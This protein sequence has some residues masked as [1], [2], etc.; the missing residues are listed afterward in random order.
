[1][2]NLAHS[3]SFESLDK[4]APS[5]AGTKQLVPNAAGRWAPAPA[6]PGSQTEPGLIVYRFG[7]DL[8]YANAD[9]F[10]DEARALVAAAPSPVRW[11][12]VDAGA[13][14]DLDYSAARTIRDLLDELAAKKVNVALAR[15]SVYLRADLER[16]RISQRVGE[17][18]IFATLH[19]AIDG[20][21]SDGSRK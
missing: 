12:V 2:Q 13:M 20:I 4:N 10:A 5:K 6:E 15:V 11:F 3:A 17:A 19:E 8:F 1:M 14:T 18:R 21:R 16:H 9:R 7:A